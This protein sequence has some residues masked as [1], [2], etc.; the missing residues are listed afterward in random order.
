V[1]LTIKFDD[2]KFRAALKDAVV[3]LKANGPELVKE[4]A[5]LFI[6]EYMKLTPPFAKGNYG[7]HV[8]TKAD[9]EAGKNVIKGDLAQVAG[10]DSR[11]HLEWIADT[12]G[13][14]Q[15]RQQL[16]KKGTNKPYFIEWDQVAF[17]IG[18][19]F[20]HHRSQL[21]KYGRPPNI[22]KGGKKEGGIATKDVGRWV[23]RNKVIVPSEV[24]FGY[25]KQLYDAIGAAKASFNEAAFALGMKR[26]P[27]WV[28]RHGNF[29][30]YSE[31]GDPANFVIF[32]GGQSKIPGAQRAV[33]Q[34]IAIRAKKFVAEL[35]RIMKGFAATGKILT[36]R[37]SFNT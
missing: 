12:F 15:I 9:Y 26:I 10:F 13:R 27:P 11:G 31:G 33:D 2:L 16:Y 18:E 4:E 22:Y 35:E 32:I 29:G 23:A 3:Q 8:G 24:Y 30:S 21:S 34:A 7:K 6:G 1:N 28:R 19:L 20:K 37:K 14:T 5:R 36:R 17:T 25:L